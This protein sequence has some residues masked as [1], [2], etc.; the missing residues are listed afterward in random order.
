[1]PMPSPATA[2][3]FSTQI[4]VALFREHLKEAKKS[5]FRDEDL[6]VAMIF[7][8]R[9]DYAQ[10]HCKK[11]VEQAAKAEGLAWLG[12][13]TVPTDNSGLGRKA[14][15]TQPVIVQALIGRV[16]E[17]HRRRIRT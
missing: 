6:G 7:L 16:G 15:E 5:L 4:P 11:L 14:L 3:V 2:R 12:W 17:L 8:P 10:A 13:R 9:D 1:M